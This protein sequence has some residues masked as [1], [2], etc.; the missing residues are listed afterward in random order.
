[1]KL[2][3]FGTQDWAADF[4]TLLIRDG[5]FE[6]AGVVTQPDKPAGRKRLLEPSPVK[7]IALAHNLRLFQPET[8]KDS[9]FLETIRACGAEI[10]VVIAYGRI[11]PKALIASVPKGFVNVHP[12]LLPRWRGPSPVQAAIAAGEKNS[13]VT[14]M[15]IDEQMDHGPILSQLLL[16]IDPHETP[17]TFMQKVKEQGGP[18]FLETLKS[19]AQGKLFPKEQDHEQAT[20]CNMLEK[21]DGRIDW[22]RPAEEIERLVRA[23]QPWPGTWTEWT[24]NRQT[25]RLKILDAVPTE[26]KSSQAPGTFFAHGND[27]LCV[28]TATHLLRIK[29]IQPEGRQPMNEQAF[30]AGYAQFFPSH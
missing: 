4:L 18:F 24:H 28:A 17:A 23:Y 10:A 27:Q 8:L 6:I 21:K 15:T 19:Y 22:T 2:L 9:S 7:R 3:F 14:V 11:L 16:E 25:I 5:F 12:S 1:M 29:K 20:Y 13:G 26:E 30:L